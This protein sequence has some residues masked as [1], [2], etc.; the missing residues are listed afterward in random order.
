MEVLDRGKTKVLIADDMRLMSRILASYVGFQPDMEV[1]GEASDGREAVEAYENLAPDVTLMDI[2][3]P[4]LDGICATREILAADPDAKVMI[5]TAHDNGPHTLLAAEAGAKGYVRKDCDPKELMSAIRRISAGENILPEGVPEQV[6]RNLRGPDEKPR[7]HLTSREIEIVEALAGGKSNKQIANTMFISER[8]VRNHASN[9]YRK[10]R[11]YD[12][13][14][15]VL[16]AAR[17]GFIDL[18]TIGVGD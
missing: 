6:A 5:L 2:S 1:A 14:Q 15:A 4:N 13:T 16:R 17:H 10:L 18:H 9:I 12:R 3:M 7:P 8:T 11:V